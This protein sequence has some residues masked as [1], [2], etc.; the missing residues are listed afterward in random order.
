MLLSQGRILLSVVL[1][2]AFFPVLTAFAQDLDDVSIRGRVVDSNRLPVAGASLKAAMVESG[3]ER[4]AATDSSGAYRFIDL[5]PGIYTLTVQM[6][7]FAT[8]ERPP[9]HTISGQNLTLDFELAPA[10]VRAQTTVNADD[11][12]IAIDTTRTVVASTLSE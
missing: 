10:G 4:T 1:F 7:G 2:C 5:P 8:I 12:E 3:Y 9:I 11:G 6:P